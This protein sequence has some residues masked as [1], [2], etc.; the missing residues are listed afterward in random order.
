MENNRKQNERKNIL[1]IGPYP[2]PYGGIATFIQN[3][4]QQE[5]LCKKYEIEL[6]KTG[7]EN[8]TTP[9]IFQIFKDIFQV[10]KF[11]VTINF[12]KIDIFHIHTAS[13]WSFIRNVP[14]L[15]ISKCLS[16]GKI[17]FHIHG[18]EFSIFFN[19]ASPLI[20]KIIQITLNY[21]DSIIVTST[22][23]IDAIKKISNNHN[24]I[25]PITNG[26]DEKTFF[27][28]PKQK[29]RGDLH[30]P[31]DNKI[32]LNIGNLEE[33]KGQ[34]FLVKCMKEI[35]KK[36]NKVIAYIIGEGSLHG[37][38][39]NLIKEYKLDNH[40]VLL[41]GD[42]PPKEISLWINACDIFVL[43]SL[44]EGNPTVMFESLACGKP[45]V[46]TSVGG[47][48]DIIVT[49]EYGLLCKPRDVKELIEKIQMALDKDWNYEKIIIYA[50]GFTWSNIAKKIIDIYNKT[51]FENS[52][53]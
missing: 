24:R 41:G 30:L 51:M 8:K 13:Y 47:I 32:L 26:F 48:P 9:I 23:W 38:L 1:I 33:H 7:R 37:H 39:N 25:Y 28:V 14:Y 19:N 15:L 11:S 16:K 12:K 52:R 21:S 6:Y 3:L 2:P 18:G 5:E 49:D 50:Q 53:N 4:I 20:K 46:G 10:L 36:E 29:I 42:K 34:K 40:V 22:S 17:I 43:P 35:I 44:N 27:P 31:H 45:F